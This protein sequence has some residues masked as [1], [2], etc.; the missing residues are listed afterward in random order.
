MCAA[1]AE[2]WRLIGTGTICGEDVPIDVNAAALTD[3]ALDANPAA[4]I[5]QVDLFGDLGND[6]RFRSDFVRARESF[7][8]QGVHATLDALLRR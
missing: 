7:A 5:E 1:W 4:F 6:S 2:Y 8:E 3:A